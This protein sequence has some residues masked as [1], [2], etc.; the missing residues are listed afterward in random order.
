MRLVKLVV[1]PFGCLLIADSSLI[2]AFS[3]L[4]NVGTC[5]PTLS[6]WG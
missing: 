1:K 4:S 2:Q 3:P 5:F 6:G